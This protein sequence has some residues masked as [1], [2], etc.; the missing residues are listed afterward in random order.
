MFFKWG[1]GQVWR[2]ENFSLFLLLCEIK[3]QGDR[4]ERRKGGPTESEN[5]FCSEV[6]SSNFIVRFMRLLTPK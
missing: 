6:H 1:G 4:G 5:Q 2:S 3:T